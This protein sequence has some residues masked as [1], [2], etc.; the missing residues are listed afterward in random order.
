MII[1]CP[2]VVVIWT[3][4]PSASIL[5]VSFDNSMPVGSRNTNPFVSYKFC[6]ASNSPAFSVLINVPQMLGRAVL[7]ETVQLLT[8]TSGLDARGEG[9]SARVLVVRPPWLRRPG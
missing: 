5:T 8:A 3:W 7:G 1:D 2:P 9:A 4:L 6:I